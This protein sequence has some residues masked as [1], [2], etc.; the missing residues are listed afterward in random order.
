MVKETVR[1]TT[2]ENKSIFLFVYCLMLLFCLHSK[3][4]MGSSCKCAL[5]PV[6]VDH[7]LSNQISAHTFGRTSSG[8]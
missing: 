2:N 5:V 4:C 7:F 6:L 1:M 3:S 8:S